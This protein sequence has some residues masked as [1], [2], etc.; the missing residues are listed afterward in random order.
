MNKE[1]LHFK[2]GSHDNHFEYCRREN[3]CGFQDVVVH[4]RDISHPDTEAQKVSV[5]QT[6]RQ[7]L[8]NQQLTSMIEVCN[9]A[10]R[11]KDG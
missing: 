4:V 11:L 2:L 6:L 5:L 1:H 8:S 9:K 3:I 7:L 10:D